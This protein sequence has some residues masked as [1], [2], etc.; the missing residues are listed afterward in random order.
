MSK[1]LG[2]GLHMRIESHYPN[3]INRFP[4]EQQKEFEKIMRMNIINNT[5]SFYSGISKSTPGPE[6]LSICLKNRMGVGEMAQ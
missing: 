4:S 2:K 1:S 6:R 5:A 3:T